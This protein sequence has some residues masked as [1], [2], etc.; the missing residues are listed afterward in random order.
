MLSPKVQETYEKLMA[1]ERVNRT[2]KFIESDHQ[3]TISEQIQLT[4]IPAPPFKEEVR[5]KIFK[6]CLKK[7]G[8]KDVKMDKEGNV[9]GVRPGT[10]NGPKLF[11]SAHLDTVFPEGTDTTVTEKDGKLYAPGIGDDTRGLAEVL[12]IVR[13]LNESSIPTVGDIIIGER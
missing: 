9:F 12:A 4:E 8:L 2:Y 6:Q 11:V 13:A 7:L 10:G 3:N 5:A 1:D